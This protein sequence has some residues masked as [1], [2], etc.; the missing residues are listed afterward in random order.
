[1]NAPVQIRNAAATRRMRR[2][3]Q[4]TRQPLTE[5]VDDAVRERL[6]RVDRQSDDER[7]LWKANIRRLVAE[8]HALPVVGPL[9]TDDD[10]YDEDGLPK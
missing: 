1:M 10:M 4:V 5:A 7:E 6:E 8:F 2:L 9:L 3:A